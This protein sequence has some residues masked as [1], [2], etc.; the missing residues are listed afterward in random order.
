VIEKR[1]VRTPTITAIPGLNEEEYPTGG[2]GGSPATSG[3]GEIEIGRDRTMEPD[4]NVTV[5]T[6]KTKWVFGFMFSGR[7]FFWGF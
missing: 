7:G 6:K 2:G 5:K 4:K 1:V 3:G